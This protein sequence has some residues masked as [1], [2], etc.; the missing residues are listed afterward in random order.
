MNCVYKLLC[1]LI[2]DEPALLVG[3]L[4]EEQRCAGVRNVRALLV[5]RAQRAA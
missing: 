3:Q 5:L 1:N 2:N 4:P